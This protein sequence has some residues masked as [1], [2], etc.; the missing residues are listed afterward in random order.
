MPH[1]RG[2]LP[3]V[4]CRGS[5]A[6]H[7]PQ[8]P[9]PLCPQP[10]ALSLGSSAS[11][12]TTL[13]RLLGTSCRSHPQVYRQLPPWTPL[14]SRPAQ[15]LPAAPCLCPMTCTLSYSFTSEGRDPTV[16]RPLSYTHRQ[17]SPT[18]IRCTGTLPRKVFRQSHSCAESLSTPLHLQNAFAHRRILAALAKIDLRWCWRVRWGGRPSQG[19]VTFPLP[20]ANPRGKWSV[21][22]APVVDMYRGC[23]PS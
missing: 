11:R 21:R 13:R 17:C 15:R 9:Q 10:S 23:I 5:L 8:R 20:C 18:G 2:V 3:S 14:A 22:R 6:G 4:A 1:E 7:V 19:A 12:T 16:D